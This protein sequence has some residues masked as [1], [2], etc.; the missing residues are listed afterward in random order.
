LIDLNAA[1]FES[2]PEF[3]T[4]GNVKTG[5]APY[6]SPEHIKSVPK[7]DSRTDVYAIGLVLY[8]IIKGHHAYRELGESTLSTDEWFSRHLHR[9]PEPLA[10]PSVWQ[11]LNMAIHKDRE[12]RY[13]SNVA[14]QRAI[15]ETLES[16]MCG[17]KPPGAT[18]PVAH[19]LRKTTVTH[20]WTRTVF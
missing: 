10:P 16:L 8:E 14:F 17:K 11:L 15:A 12:Q 2:Y 9:E 20:G 4:T 18:V 1:R 7:L 13:E 19:A 6:M 5:T 3:T